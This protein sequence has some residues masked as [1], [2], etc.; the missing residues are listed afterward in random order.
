MVEGMTAR[1]RRKTRISGDLRQDAILSAAEILLAERAFDDIS[2]EEFANAAGISRSNFYFY[3]SSKDEMLLALLD[4]V[5]TEVE[6]EV[7]ALPRAFDRDAAAAWRSAIGVFVDVFRS[8][9]AVSA[10]AIAAR[11]RS[12]EVLALW[13]ESMQS[14][15]DYSTEIITAER[16]RGA[17]PSGIDA[18]DLAVALNLMN[19]RVLSASF[20]A[21]TLS[22]DPDAALD[23][24]S[25]IWIRSI[26]GTRVLRS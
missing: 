10:A 5:I 9:R 22:I 4:R 7:G 14:W 21:E 8:H 24:L 1:G 23:T 17:A 25:S 13:T 16:A 6:R 19:E 11:S 3:F 15:V 20:S 12:P 18:H 26:Y 2:I